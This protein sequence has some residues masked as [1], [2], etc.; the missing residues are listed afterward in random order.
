MRIFI[1]NFTEKT[2]SRNVIFDK[3]EIYSFI[4]DEWSPFG[5]Y[6]YR[7][8]KVDRTFE[9]A[10]YI[11]KNYWGG[12]LASVLSDD[13]NAYIKSLLRRSFSI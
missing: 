5:E 10:E 12:H 1:K 6:E 8:D 7:V 4:P 3:P 13:E 2:L 11:C 9:D